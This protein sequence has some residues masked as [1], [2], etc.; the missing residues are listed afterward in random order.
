MPEARIAAVVQLADSIARQAGIGASGSFDLPEPAESISQWLSISPEQLQQI[1]EKLS[2]TVR[3][4]SNILGL[5]LPKAGANYCKIVHT[6][7]A[8][9]ARQHT[10]LSGENRRL[11]SDSS[12]LDFIT[13]F[14]LGINPISGASDIAEDF[15]ARWQKFYQT[16]LVCLYLAPWRRSQTLEAVV[17]ESLS[18][19]RMV[20]LNAPAETSVIPKTIANNFAILNAHD[21]IDWLFEQLDV[22]FDVNRTK[23]MPLL[24]GRKAVGAIAFELN[25]PGDVE[26]FE[27]KFR[28]SAS[29]AGVVLGMALAQQRQQHF[30]ERFARLISKPKDTQTRAATA[31]NSLN[32]LAEM[33]AGAAHELNN[34][35]AVISGRAQLLADA[36]SDQEKKKILEQIYKNAR[37]TSAIIEDL[38]SFA[39]P[40]EARAAQTDIKQMLDE[41]IQLARQKTNAE[42]L[43]VQIAA[44]EGIESVFVDSAQV[45]SAIANVISNAVESYGDK[46]GPIKITADT[47]ESGDS[48]KLQISDT[49]C[50]MDAETVQKATQPFFSVKPAGRK[51]GMGL[52]YAVRFIQLNKGSLNI[53]SE[54]GSGTT[55]TICLP[56]K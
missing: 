26:L 46:P 22:D 55:V 40:P 39:E 47:T 4:K 11:Q 37:E 36:E 9:L 51:R 24:S 1:R 6:A 7:A 29:I 2:E 35:L 5:Y 34:P 23:L 19:S 43:D 28:T 20:C 53:A 27:E 18:Q 17:V 15:A 41:A 8:Q 31:E 48:V 13:D 10:E 56:R 50:G 32:A 44:A 21:H 12:H 49:G 54:P 52:A 42:H 30:A 14:L 33:A 38:M 45:V 25:Y 16:G 3:Q